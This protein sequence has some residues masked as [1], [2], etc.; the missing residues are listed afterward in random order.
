MIVFT[1]GE[2]RQA[3]A[4]CDTIS[5]IYSNRKYV[6]FVISFKFPL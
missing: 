3:S 6:Y 2:H 1:L 4:G 5:Y